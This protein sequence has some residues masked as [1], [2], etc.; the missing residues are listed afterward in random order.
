MCVRE[1]WEG[2]RERERGEGGEQV[3]RE[4]FLRF[5]RFGRLERYR[6]ETEIQ[7]GK[8]TLKQRDILS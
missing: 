3:S 7:K 1:G 2:V 4:A 6:G 8:E 5:S